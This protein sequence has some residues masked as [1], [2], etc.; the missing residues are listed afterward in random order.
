MNKWMDGGDKYLLARASASEV[1]TDFLEGKERRIGE[2]SS[3][4][5]PMQRPS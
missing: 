5:A 2:L 3:I 1:K 4:K